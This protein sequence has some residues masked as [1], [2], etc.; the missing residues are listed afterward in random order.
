[1]YIS[2]DNITKKVTLN[3]RVSKFSTN[4]CNAMERNNAETLM[5]NE[6]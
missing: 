6:D 3:I 2:Q 4:A 5:A 1:M